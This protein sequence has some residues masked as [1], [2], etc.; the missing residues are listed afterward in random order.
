MP[1]L[2]RDCLSTFETSTRCPVCRSPRV[3]SHPEL[4][5]L[6]IAHMDCDA[7]YAS[8][9]KRDNPDLRDKPVIIG[10]GNIGCSVAYHLAEMGCKDVVLLER[11]QLTSGTTWHAAGLISQGRA[12]PARR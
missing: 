9:E 12:S 4:F 10:G 3:T 6:T 7:F 1:S 2:C 5:D 11:D 8:V